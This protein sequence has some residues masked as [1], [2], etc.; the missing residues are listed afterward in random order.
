GYPVGGGTPRVAA[1]TFLNPNAGEY[2]SFWCW[3]AARFELPGGGVSSTFFEGLKAG[4]DKSLQPGANCQASTRWPVPTVDTGGGERKWWEEMEYEATGPLRGAPRRLAVVVPGAIVEENETTYADVA[5]AEGRP[6]DY[7]SGKVPMAFAGHVAKTSVSGQLPA[8]DSSLCAGLPD[9][10]EVEIDTDERG[11]EIEARQRR[12]IAC[13]SGARCDSGTCVDGQCT[14][15]LKVRRDYDMADRLVRTVVDPDGY[16]NAKEVEYGPDGQVSRTVAWIDDD[17]A[18]GD[19]RYCPTCPAGVTP[20]GSYGLTVDMLYDRMGR[21][22]AE[23]ARAPDAEAFSLTAHDAGGGVVF[24]LRPGSGADAGYVR[25]VISAI[26]ADGAGP[27]QVLEAFDVLAMGEANLASD[28]GS[29][30]LD[31]RLVLSSFDYDADGDVAEESVTD[32][33]SPSGLPHDDAAHGMRRRLFRDLDGALVAA[34]SARTDRTDPGGIGRIVEHSA[35]DKERRLTSQRRLDPFGPPGCAGGEAVLEVEWSD[36]TADGEARKVVTR[37]Y[38]GVAALAEDGVTLATPECRLDR[39]LS[40]VEHEYDLRGQQVRTTERRFDLFG[41]AADP[42]AAP[43]RVTRR[44]FDHAGR[45]VESF[46][47]GKGG[48]RLDRWRAVHAFFGPQCWEAGLVDADGGE[49]PIRSVATSFTSGG[50]VAGR[51]ETHH[52]PAAPVTVASAYEWDVVGRLVREIDAVGQVRQRAL[53][54]SQDRVRAVA[55]ERDSW[56]ETRYDGLGN[57]AYKAFV[58][59]VNGRIEHRMTHRGSFLVADQALFNGL[60]RDARAYQYDAHGNQA[61]TLVGGGE[62]PEY[63][64]ELRN[65][66]GQVLR[67]VAPSGAST[68]TT[69]DAL[70]SPEGLEVTSPGLGSSYKLP[71]TLRNRF[72]VNAARLQWRHDALGQTTMA[73][74]LGQDGTPISTV[75]LAWDSHGNRRTDETR[76]HE[77]AG[78][79]RNDTSGFAQPV[80]FV[81]RAKATY[82][83]RGN[84]VGLDYGPGSSSAVKLSYEHDDAGR[85]V[86][87]GAGQRAGSGGQ[88]NHVWLDHVTYAW[89]GALPA[90]RVSAIGAENQALLRLTTLYDHD[91]RGRRYRVR[92]FMP[93][94]LKV[95]EHRKYFRRGDEAFSRAA[96]FKDGEEQGDLG[97]LID[98]RT[99]VG[100]SILA[101]DL[102]MSFFSPLDQYDTYDDT[103][104]LDSTYT[105]F[106]HDAHG[107]VTGNVTTSYGAFSGTASVQADWRK[108]EGDRMRSRQQLT[109]KTEEQGTTWDPSAR[110]I[111]ATHSVLGWSDEGFEAPGRSAIRRVSHYRLK[112]PGIK[113][114]SH[115]GLVLSGDGTLGGKEPGTAVA[116]LAYTRSGLPEH[117]GFTRLDWPKTDGIR[118]RFRFDAF[119]QLVLVEGFE[120]GACSAGGPVNDGATPVADRLRIVW[121]ALGRRIL[122]DYVLP[123]DCDAV[124]S[125]LDNER[126]RILQYF[127]DALLQETLGSKNAFSPDGL[128]SYVYGPGDM[129]YAGVVFDDPYGTDDDYLVLDDAD[130][131]SSAVWDTRN[132]TFKRPGVPAGDADMGTGGERV[133]WT[134]EGNSSAWFR[135]Y[136]TLR[137]T[138]NFAWAMQQAAPGQERLGFG[139]LGYAWG[140]G[141]TFDLIADREGQRSRVADWTFP[142]AVK[143][144]GRMAVGSVLDGLLGWVGV[145]KSAKRLG[146]GVFDGASAASLKRRGWQLGKSIGAVIQDMA[147]AAFTAGVGKVATT[148]MRTT[149]RAQ[150][151]ATARAAGLT[152]REVESFEAA[153]R[154][155]GGDL[156][157]GVRSFGTK[158]MSRRLSVAKGLLAKPLW[159]KGKTGA[160]ATR[161]W[162]RGPDR[163]TSRM[164]KMRV[165][166][167]IDLSHVV[168]NGRPVPRDAVEFRRAWRGAYRALPGRNNPGIKHGPHVDLAHV[169][170]GDL[171]FAPGRARPMA[172]RFSDPSQI[173]GLLKKIGPPKKMFTLEFA[174]L[175]N[176]KGS[177]LAAVR[178]VGMIENLSLVRASAPDGGWPRCWYTETVKSYS[179]DWVKWAREVILPQVVTTSWQD[180]AREFAEEVSDTIRAS[181]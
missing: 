140:A 118:H 149:T 116:D 91:V 21:R 102:P 92:H 68:R 125:F 24:E 8:E 173:D 150:A 49:T 34:E 47:E 132:A 73:R 94:E 43:A 124:Q 169:R 71:A 109:W 45:V 10:L 97:R 160:D 171:T 105:A 31:P 101:D 172:E 145:L 87:I 46:V 33:V 177:R 103:N 166:A 81:H 53:Y 99:V 144:L 62:F 114:W 121:D 146:M 4:V 57:V 128:A 178:E 6:E 143:W 148:A 129:P 113:F 63:A 135:P 164:P 58:T 88:F 89:K 110:V 147:L 127:G 3:R 66:E 54:D 40:Q 80:T 174:A 104:P 154:K 60:A 35:Y 111:A 5:Y 18:A 20:Q 42:D 123:E 95:F 96:Y 117:D 133:Q 28:A 84:M 137:V 51:V 59:L 7:R 100:G 9:R 170:V 52:D 38:D 131:A 30:A 167:D 136:S 108:L 107:N 17:F 161:L 156:T 44:V 85:L 77:A 65:E 142:G 48:G 138:P 36:F 162:D 32:G 175:R 39:V 50:D 157:V 27:R 122:A 2:P 13:T 120:P 93:E 86:R 181:R 98:E 29:V 64:E 179:D 112:D 1:T 67:R 163:A 78:L 83:D 155:M 69:Y 176:G 130:G 115:G 134:F 74:N 11:N 25:Q 23:V 37:G 15:T 16:A 82:D 165:V 159:E 14:A 19:T 22:W 61:R 41:D 76:G 158:A 153:A 141:M 106:L 12:R 72:F 126:P 26:E 55:D 168:H 56:E 79:V 90:G 139:Q 75:L 180:F 152:M 151:R 70:G 119:D